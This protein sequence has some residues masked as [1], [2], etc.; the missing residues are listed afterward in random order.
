MF[1][2]GLKSGY[3]DAEDLGGWMT[4]VEGGR[5]DYGMIQVN[6]SPGHMEGLQKL[7]DEFWKRFSWF[8]ISC[9]C[10]FSS[11]FLCF[12]LFFFGSLPALPPPSRRSTRRKRC[13]LYMVSVD[14]ETRTNLG[15][16]QYLSA[17]ERKNVASCLGRT[18]RVLAGG[19]SRKRRG[20]VDLVIY[21]MLVEGGVRGVVGGEGGGEREGLGGCIPA[22][23][24]LGLRRA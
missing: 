8:H 13:V 7:L 1:C 11:F 17:E 24:V 16:K 20:T 19:L 5:K 22:R 4:V 2:A 9:C 12:H 10:S 18:A 3:V 21:V 15:R 23:E 6:K 14:W